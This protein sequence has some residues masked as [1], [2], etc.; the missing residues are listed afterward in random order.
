IRTNDGFITRINPSSYMTV[1]FKPIAGL[2]Q[3]RKY[4][5]LQFMPLTIELSLVDNATDPQMLP[6]LKLIL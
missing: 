4:L 6:R 2:L 3:V 1:I 5:P